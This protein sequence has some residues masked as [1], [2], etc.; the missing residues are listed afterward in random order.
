MA[1]DLAFSLG[2]SGK[3]VCIVTSRLSY[4]DPH[5]QL[6]SHE[7]LDHVEI[8]RV[9][10]T[11]F[12]RPNL[13]G[14]AVDYAS[15]Y[16]SA[17]VK[18]LLV[19]RK[20]DVIIAKTDPP[21]ISIVAW[22]AASI[23]G[24]RLINWLQDIFPETAVALGVLR[25]K[26]VVAFTQWARNLSIRNADMNVAIGEIM[27]QRLRNL[28]V[29]A[30]KISIIQNWA[31]GSRIIPVDNNA[32]RFR[33]SW[34][35]QDKFVV[36]YSGNMGRSHDFDTIIDAMKRLESSAEIFFLFI[37][38]G[39]GKQYLQAAFDKFDL[40]NYKFMPY[41]EQHDLSE[42]L[43]VADVHLVSLKPELE[44]LIVPSKIYGIAAAA[45][46]VVFIGSGDGEVARFIQHCNCG[47]SIDQG[48][49]ESLEKLLGELSGDKD[50]TRTLGENGRACLEQELD[51]SHATARWN[52]ML[53]KYY[54]PGSPE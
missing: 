33:A 25:W 37:G 22:A 17:L 41:Q 51:K 29:A 44:G 13:A 32:N 28:G 36:G 19:T 34:G 23:K 26:P 45:R 47:Y 48:D 53:D 18:L 3:R 2:S 8:F 54:H 42:S 46:P 14:R 38:G 21:L 30:E 52:D 1:S 24:A 5:S 31:D 43:S 6:P 9:W 49:G 7:T 20:G 40:R 12:G 4:E 11:R 39:A 10:T 27:Q 35:L 16:L 50:R 15:F